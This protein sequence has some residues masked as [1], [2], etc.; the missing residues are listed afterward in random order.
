MSRSRSAF[1]LIELLVVIAIIA[2]LAAILF[3]VFAQAKDAAKNTAA[4]SNFKQAGLANLMYTTDYDD[5]FALCAQ[6]DDAGWNTWQHMIQPYTKNWGVLLHPKVQGPAGPQAYW[7]QLLHMGV[8]PTAASVTGNEATYTWTDANFTAGKTVMHDGLFGHGVQGE[9]YWYTDKSAP[10]L[11]TTQ[12]DRPSE[13]AMVM[14]AAGWDMYFSVL[15]KTDTLD[16]CGT[17]GAGWS[18]YGS[19][20]WMTSGQVPRKNVKGAQIGCVFMDGFVQYVATD[21]SAK[22][23]DLR[24]K[25]WGEKL[26]SDGTYVFPLMWPGSVD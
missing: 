11:S 22:S 2:I 23:A 16:Y 24:G 8:H 18:P 19:D 3:P 17:W 5:L 14:D 15:P 25:F 12:I 21:G 7:Q 6:S 4:L 13:V 1:T 9:G 26:R 10:S 20:G